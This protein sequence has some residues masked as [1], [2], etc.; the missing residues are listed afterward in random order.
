MKDRNELLKRKINGYL[1]KEQFFKNDEHKKQEK[2]FIAKSRKNFTVAKL[3]FKISEEEDMRR[4]LN[5]ASGFEMDDWAI[6]VSYYSMY[7]SSLSALANL[8]F[9]SKSHAA[10]IAVLEY[11]FAKDKKLETKDIHKLVKACA[12]SEQLITKLIQTKTKRETAQYDAT[13]SITREMAKSSL[14]DADEFITKIE[15]MLS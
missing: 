12:L 11:N 5:L 14:D 9:K 10:T 15:E 2:P 4:I 6:I 3:L 7:T 13:S 8:G 1:K